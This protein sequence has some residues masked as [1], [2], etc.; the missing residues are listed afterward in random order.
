MPRREHCY[1]FLGGDTAPSE[2]RKSDEGSLMTGVATPRHLPDKDQDLS[3]NEGDWYF[4]FVH[5]RVFNA[6]Q[7]LSARQ[8]SGNIHEQH[9][10]FSYEKIVLDAG[11]GGGGVFVKRELMAPKQLIHGI[12]HEVTPLCDQVDGP[13][14]VVRGRFIVHMFKRGDPGIESVWPNPEA[15]N[16]SLAG[17]ELL[18]D[19]L[20]SD[21]KE[22]ADHGGFGWPM[23]V[24]DFIAQHPGELERWPE[25]RRWALK[26]LDACTKQLANVVV[27]T[28]PDGT[29]AFTKRGAHQF[30]TIG[31]DDI[32]LS[33]MYCYAAFRIWLRS[34]VWK[35]DAD[36]DD[37]A[38]FGY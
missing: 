13:K 10:R 34:D 12:E 23:K 30:S 38:G 35:R 24:K 21:F 16:K 33:A 31:R 28:R 17:D 3:E 32:A 18:K 22:A 29:Y 27:A 4:D 20:Y 2:S 5:C 6:R 1:F 26:N 36:P 19:A 8:W 9:Q 15:T 7:K 25:E 37:E 14:L 11:A